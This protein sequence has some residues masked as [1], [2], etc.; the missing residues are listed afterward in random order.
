MR[1]SDNSMKVLERRYLRKDEYGRT[2]ESPEEMLWRVAGWVALAE[3]LDRREYWANEFYMIMDNLDFLPNSPTLMN[4]G[5]ERGLLSACFVIPIEDSIDGI[6]SALRWAALVSKEGGGTGF[7]FS[8]LRPKGDLVKSTCG[9]ASGPLSFMELFNHTTEVVMQG[10]MRRGANMGVLNVDH[11]DIIDFVKAKTDNDKFTNFN[12]SVGITNDFMKAV[13]ADQDWNLVNPRNG[14]IVKTVKA[15]ELFDLI[16][17][18]AWRTG[19]P[20]LLFLDTINDN[21]PVPNCGRIESSNPCGEQPLIPFES[22]NLGSINLLNFYKDNGIDWNRLKDII[23]IAVRFLDDVID[24]NY[25]PISQIEETTKKTRKIGLGIMGW[26][27]LLYKLGIPYNSQKALDL[28]EK[29]MR[30]ITETGREESCALAEER[31][32]FPAWEGSVWEK[33]GIKVRN[34]TITTIAPTGTISLVAGVSSGIEPNFALA[35]RRKAFAKESQGEETLVYVNPILIDRL[36]GLDLYTESMIDQIIEKGSLQH[37]DGIPKSIKEIFVTAHDIAPKWH[38][39]MQAAF[40]RYTD[41]AVSKTI[42][43]PSNATREAVANAFMLAYGLNCK[44]IT[45]FRDGCKGEQVLNVG[46]KEPVVAKPS[47][48]DRPN[49]LSGNTLKIST[50]YGNLYL[51]LNRDE[52]GRPFEVFATLGKSGKDTQAHTEAIGRLVSLALRSGISINDVIKQLKGIG[53]STQVLDENLF[54]MIFSVPDAIAKGLEM[55]INGEINNHELIKGDVC[56]TCGAPL[57]YEEGCIHC[58]SCGFSKC[59]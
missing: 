28:A 50:S 31:G 14:Q 47:K 4:A 58:V 19:D 30:F 2:I 29:V 21:N 41:N 38:I 52:E 24:V 59:G 37:I 26:A 18:C 36:K 23:R 9:V 11:P 35:Y 55:L 8:R 43:L 13:E 45:V 51:T 44:G 48:K 49:M 39:K 32:V 5:K 54:A 1:L 6:F 15:K 42:N 46:A 16:V 3:K 7:S 33:R 17:D 56:P 57:V 22:C 10:G 40:Q 25:Y 53:G 12:I 34:A 20:G 27:D